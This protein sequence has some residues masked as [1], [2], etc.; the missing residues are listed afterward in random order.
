MTVAQHHSG[1]A[2]AHAG[3]P[4]VVRSTLHDGEEDAT[5]RHRKAEKH[6]NLRNCVN[7]DILG[8]TMQ[9]SSR[10]ILPGRTQ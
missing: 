7:R 10:E 2:C 9:V 8:I 5:K 4:W 6:V 3:S 1:H